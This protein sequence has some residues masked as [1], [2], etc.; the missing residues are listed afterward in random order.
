MAYPVGSILFE[1]RQPWHVDVSAAALGVTVGPLQVRAYDTTALETH[2]RAWTEASAVA[3][4]LFP[5]KAVP[6]ARLVELE[7]RAA[8]RAIDEPIERR[9][10]RNP[11]RPPGPTSP[12]RDGP[13]RPGPEPGTGP[14]P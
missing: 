10:H 3:A 5:G 14:R 13:E 6:F 4:R 8:L 7:R 2:I 12:D 9:Y 1:G 11:L